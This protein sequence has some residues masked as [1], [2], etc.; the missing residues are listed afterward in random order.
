MNFNTMFFLVLFSFTA[1]QCSQKTYAPLYP[2]QNKLLAAAESGD[3][4][5]INEILSSVDDDQELILLTKSRTKTGK[6]PQKLLIEKGKSKFAAALSKRITELNSKKEKSTELKEKKENSEK[7]ESN[8]SSSTTSSTRRNTI[9][10]SPKTTKSTSV[11]NECGHSNCSHQPSHWANPILLTAAV[12]LF[13]GI[14][15][16]LLTKPSSGNQNNGYNHR[17]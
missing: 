6:T 9:L 3:T 5:K 13:S 11:H 4:G 10:K 2:I 14:V 1:A 7:E 12:G 8:D 17:F 15:M 16:H